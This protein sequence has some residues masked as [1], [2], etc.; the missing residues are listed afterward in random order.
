MHYVRDYAFT[1]T[2]G[3]TKGEKYDYLLVNGARQVDGE[4]SQMRYIPVSQKLKLNKRFRKTSLEYDDLEADKKIENIVLAPRGI[5]KEEV[6]SMRKCFD[7]VGRPAQALTE[8]IIPL[9]GSNKEAREIEARA[10]EPLK[11]H[12]VVPKY[13]QDDQAMK[14]KHELEHEEHKRIDDD[15]DMS[16]VSPQQQ[17]SVQDDLIESDNKDLFNGQ[18]DPV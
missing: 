2:F 16:A 11:S 18:Q 8:G 14:P 13:D 10:A 9:F 7:E 15:A 6:R 4:V 3:G 12:F 5:S 17:N 1:E